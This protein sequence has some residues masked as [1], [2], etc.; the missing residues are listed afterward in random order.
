[1]SPVPTLNFHSTQLLVT[2][3][4]TPELSLVLT[5]LH[6]TYPLLQILLIAS[7]CQCHHIGSKQA[8]NNGSVTLKG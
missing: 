8:S 5:L 1:M 7:P 6:A 4:E 3:F 2:N